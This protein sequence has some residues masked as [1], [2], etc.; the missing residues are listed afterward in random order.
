MFDYGRHVH[1]HD[2]G[3]GRSDVGDSDCYLNTLDILTQACLWVV[4]YIIVSAVY[5]VFLTRIC[6]VSFYLWQRSVL[7]SLKLLTE[8]SAVFVSV[9]SSEACAY[10]SQVARQSGLS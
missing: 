10:E 7:Y 1:H 4:C 9:F 3:A 5:S 8:N 2:V 6:K